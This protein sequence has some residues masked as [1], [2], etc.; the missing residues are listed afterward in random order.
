MYY[1]SSCVLVVALYDYYECV[2]YGCNM[3]EEGSGDVHVPAVKQLCREVSG[4]VH[5]VKSQHCQRMLFQCFFVAAAT[6][7]YNGKKKLKDVFLK[8]HL[9]FLWATK[10]TY[11]SLNS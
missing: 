1:F 8:V 2:C 6:I 3:S 9:R 4:C 5:S 11:F 10:I 7:Y